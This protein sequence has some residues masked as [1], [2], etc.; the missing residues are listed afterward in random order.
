L[1]SVRRSL[2]PNGESFP[3]IEQ[4]HPTPRKP[5]LAWC[6][7]EKSRIAEAVPDQVLEVVRPQ[8]TE[9]PAPQG[10]DNDRYGWKQQRPDHPV[11][12]VS[13]QNAR[14][15]CR[16]L[17][18]VTGQPWRLPTEAEW[19]K[20]ARGT[21]GRIYPWGSEW[22]KLRANTS[23]GGPGGTTEVGHYSG[24]GSRDPKG[25]ASP[26]GC[27]DMAGNVWEWTSTAW[28]DRPPYDANKYENDSDNIHVLRGSS[29]ND[30]PRV[31]RAAFRYW[32]VWDGWKD[33][34]GFRLACGWRAG[35]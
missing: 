15:Y 8:R 29:W 30:N 18:Q 23:D 16:W 19:E 12:C 27:H 4:R 20:A 34:G 14:D 35:I 28:Y 25:D 22:D 5:I 21:D 3:E 24:A 17:A 7:R 6:G 31:A 9:V 13:W 33:D 11:V 26:Y 32:G 10:Q 2:T 1:I